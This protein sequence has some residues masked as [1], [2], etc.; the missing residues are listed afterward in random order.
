MAKKKKGVVKE[1]VEDFLNPHNCVEI[2]K[3]VSC[4]F[5]LS[6]SVGD[7][8]ELEEKQMESLVDNDFA[9]WA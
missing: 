4:K 5:G 7:V 9:K 2:L 1:C 3:P 6:C 8:V